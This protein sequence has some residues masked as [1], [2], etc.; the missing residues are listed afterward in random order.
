[1]NDSY[2]LLTLRFVQLVSKALAKFCP[3]FIAVSE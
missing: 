2:D 3:K 1:M